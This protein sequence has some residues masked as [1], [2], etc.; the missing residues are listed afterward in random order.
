MYLNLLFKTI[1]T[2][3]NLTCSVSEEIST[4]VSIFQTNLI[5]RVLLTIKIPV[6]SQIIL[7][8]AFKQRSLI[9]WTF[10][11]TSADS[12]HQGSMGNNTWD[13]IHSMKE[14]QYIYVMCRSYPRDSLG[15]QLSACRYPIWT[16]HTSHP[17]FS[18]FLAHAFKL[19]TV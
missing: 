3:T 14:N 15:L 10:S 11:T 9:A 6:S 18:W 8:Q 12:F 13:N 16:S 19:S 4:K 1:I 2:H 5:I 17:H 7:Y